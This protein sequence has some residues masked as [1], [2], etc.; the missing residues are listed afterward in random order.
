VPWGPL[1]PAARRACRRRQRACR[2]C[3]PACSGPQAGPSKRTLRARP[4]VA[5]VRAAPARVTFIGDR[6]QQTRRHREASS[7]P[8]KEER[9]TH[10][11]CQVQVFRAQ[12]RADEKA[13]CHWLQFRHPGTHSNICQRMLV[14]S[15]G[16]ERPCRARVAGS[17]PRSVGLEERNGFPGVLCTLALHD[18]AHHVRLMLSRVNPPR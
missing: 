18:E 10:L 4:A 2:Q 15:A 14:A 9:N 3:A 8:G 1:L 17:A 5:G 16:V 13:A 12:A 7:A 6:N 11:Q